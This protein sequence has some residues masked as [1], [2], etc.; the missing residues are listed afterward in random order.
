MNH[1]TQINDRARQAR[2]A[3]ALMRGRAEIARQSSADL[4]GLCAALEGRMD[5]ESGAELQATM[6]TR[7]WVLDELERRN[8]ALVAEMEV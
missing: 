5:G 1:N 3:I 4:I 2:A 6:L 7:A 8:P